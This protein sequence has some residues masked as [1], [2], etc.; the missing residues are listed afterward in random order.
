[1]GLVNWWVFAFVIRMVD[2][3]ALDGVSFRNFRFWAFSLF[4]LLK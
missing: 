1:M 2:F 3:L 4:V